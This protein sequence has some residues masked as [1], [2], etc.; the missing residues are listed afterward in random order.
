MLK[1]TAF[2]W[3]EMSKVNHHYYGILRIKVGIYADETTASSIKQSQ[4]V[5]ACN[6]KKTFLKRKQR[7]AFARMPTTCCDLMAVG[8]S[9][10]YVTISPS[11]RD[12]ARGRGGWSKGLD[13]LRPRVVFDR[14]TKIKNLKTL[15]YYL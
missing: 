3:E 5:C 9:V 7:T 11:S 4:N 12:L 14:N 8:K 10:S 1:V 13:S 6:L 2:R 15:A